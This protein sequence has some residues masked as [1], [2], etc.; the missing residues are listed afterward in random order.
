M[1][2]QKRM[3]FIGKTAAGKTT[4]CQYLT[5]QDLKY[6]KTQTIS[7]IGGRLIDTPG[8]YLERVRMRGALSV[9]AADADIILFV[10]DATAKEKMFPPAYA[11]SFA[12]PCVGIVTKSDIATEKQIAEAKEHLVHAGARAV[13]VTSSVEGTGFK[14]LFEYLDQL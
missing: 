7:V 3:M 13:F 1:I 12:K 4:L 8:E 5:D 9:T 2:K 6:H 14:E 11:G 10:Q